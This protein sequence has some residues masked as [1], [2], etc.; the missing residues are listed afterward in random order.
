MKSILRI[1][2]LL[3]LVLLCRGENGIKAK[4][5]SKQISAGTDVCSEMI[6]ARICKQAIKGQQVEGHCVTSDT[7]NCIYRCQA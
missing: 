5:C 1:V 3:F 7:C 6:C 4:V 2:I